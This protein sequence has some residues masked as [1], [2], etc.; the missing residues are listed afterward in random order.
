MTDSKQFF[1]VEEANQRLPLV[2]RIVRDIVALHK[3]VE[4]RRSRFEEIQFRQTG[5]ED[6]ASIYRDEVAEVEKEIEKDSGRLKAFVDELQ[7]LNVV[8]KNPGQGVVSFPSMMDDREVCLCWIP[9]DEE[10]GYWHEVDAGSATRQ[11][12]FEES[13]ASPDEPTESNGE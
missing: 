1:T 4:E 9:G 6:G 7:S 12:L 10:V 5:S 11:S 13:I 2:K 8:L 3:D